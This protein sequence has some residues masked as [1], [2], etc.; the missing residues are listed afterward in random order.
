MQF[1][2]VPR[3]PVD[4]VIRELLLRKSIHDQQGIESNFWPTLHTPTHS[5]LSFTEQVPRCVS[6]ATI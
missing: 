2:S 1:P 3:S 4:V 6:T 5:L